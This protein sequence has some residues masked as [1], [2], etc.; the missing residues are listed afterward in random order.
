[1]FEH[2]RHLVV[3]LPMNHTEELAYIE[4]TLTRPDLL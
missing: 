3:E 1:M 4:L 2:D